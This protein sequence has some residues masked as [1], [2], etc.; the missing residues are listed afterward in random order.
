MRTLVETLRMVYVNIS[1]IIVDHDDASTIGNL[2][3]V[4]R[5]VRVLLLLLV[6]VMLVQRLFG[7]AHL[8]RTYPSVV[9]SLLLRTIGRRNI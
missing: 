9:S 1:V 8:V 3:H 5:I 6:Q 2:V 7:H 4:L